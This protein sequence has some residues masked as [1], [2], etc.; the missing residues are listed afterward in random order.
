MVAH[1]NIVSDFFRVAER[2]LPWVPYR[3]VWRK[4]IFAES[5][6]IPEYM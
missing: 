5:I 1:T 4:N 3:Y 6:H 2:K